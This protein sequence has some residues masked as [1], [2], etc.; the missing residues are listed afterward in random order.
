[1]KVEIMAKT[2]RSVNFGPFGYAGTFLNEDTPDFGANPAILFIQPHFRNTTGWIGF[3]QILE[4]Y[5]AR[6]SKLPKVKVLNKMKLIE[7]EYLSNVCM[8]EDLEGGPYNAEPGFNANWRND[9]ERRRHTY[10]VEL[11]QRFC[12]E[13]LEIL[14]SFRKRLAKVDD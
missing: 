6:L 1:M 3:P 5:N 4:G 7:I 2:L 8:G 11:L 14:P 10:D 13:L 12:S 9:L